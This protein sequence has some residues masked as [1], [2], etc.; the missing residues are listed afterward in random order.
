MKRPA[1]KATE[2]APCL[3]CGSVTCD[4]WHPEVAAY[5]DGMKAIHEVMDQMEA[6]RAQSE[7][8]P[9]RAA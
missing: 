3:I 5:H 1:T 6:K 2:A 8:E 4:K 7:E 9:K